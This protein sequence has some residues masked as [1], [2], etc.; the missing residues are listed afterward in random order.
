MKSKQTAN[1]LIIR[2][3][4]GCLWI[5]GLFFALI[6][7]IFMYG[8]LGGFTNWNE[9]GFWQLGLSFLMGAIALS[10]GCRQIFRAPVSKIIIN[11]QTKTV[12]YIKRGL[13]GRE[14]TVYGFDRIRQ[15]RTLEENDGDGD[16]VWYFAMELLSG[17][18]IKISS[19]ST[20]FKKSKQNIAFESNK[21][22]NKQM[23]S[24]KNKFEIDG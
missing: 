4:P 24:Y 11:R 18:I 19:L 14:V 17:E 15:F 5:F 20:H 9:I 7:G 21:F 1:E 3:T 8:S 22:M 12:T 6:G 16:Q 10:F 2:E 13:T 23:P